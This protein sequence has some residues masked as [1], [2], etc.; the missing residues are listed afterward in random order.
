MYHLQREI[1]LRCQVTIHFHLSRALWAQSTLTHMTSLNSHCNPTGEHHQPYDGEAEAWGPPGSPSGSACTSRHR[2]SSAWRAMGCGFRQASKEGRNVRGRLKACWAIRT[3][4]GRRA[5]VTSP[6]E[7]WAQ[8][9]R[10][11]QALVLC[12]YLEAPDFCPSQKGVGRE[13]EGEA[14]RE[15]IHSHLT[16]VI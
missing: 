9:R 12:V 6:W 10:G 2:R 16:S 14:Q 8:V 11:R 15:N 4:Q 13:L 5:A 1:A 7:I 3:R